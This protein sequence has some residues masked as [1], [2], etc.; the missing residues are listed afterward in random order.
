MGLEICVKM[1]NDISSFP[2]FN[3]WLLV[4]LSKVSFGNI[5]L[6]QFHNSLFIF[7]LRLATFYTK[8]E[9][10]MAFFRTFKL[11]ASNTRAFDLI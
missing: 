9:M 1:C 10:E 3:Q 11:D 2:S 5:P 8:I 7:L 4:L 6:L